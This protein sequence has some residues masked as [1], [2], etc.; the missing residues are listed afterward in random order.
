MNVLF[1]LALC[2]LIKSNYLALN[3]LSCFVR[4]AIISIHLDVLA[5]VVA[6]LLH[7]KSVGSSNV[8]SLNYG[9]RSNV[10]KSKT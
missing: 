10:K 7:V 9:L 5:D 3:D 1:G 2:L 8:L 4:L 6:Y